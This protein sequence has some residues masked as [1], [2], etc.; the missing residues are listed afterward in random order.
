MICSIVITYNPNEVLLKSIDELV[1]QTDFVLIIDNNSADKAILTE[2]ESRHIDRV[3]MICNEQNAGVA[4]ALNQGLD[5]AAKNNFELILT[6]DQDSVLLPDCVERLLATLNGNEKIASAGANYKNI[7]SKKTYKFVD[8]LITSGNLVWVDKA[9][10][11]GGFNSELFIDGVDTEFSFKLIDAGYKLAY[12]FSAEIE[13]SIG[14]IITVKTFFGKRKLQYHSPLRYYYIYRNYE[15]LKKKF[16]KSHK[17][18][19]AKLG[20]AHWIDRT[21]NVPKH[22]DF[23]EKKKMIKQSKADAKAMWDKI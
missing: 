21:F 8:A 10:E 9:L 17:A 20:L 11:V 12:V 16:G 5:Y 4:A 7:D 19:L 1:C 23:K 3:K 6:M 18:Y 13:H 14:E 15:Y 2:I 22:S